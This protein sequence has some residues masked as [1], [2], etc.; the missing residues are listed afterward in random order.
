MCGFRPVEQ[1]AADIARVPALRDAIGQI[2][3]DRFRSAMEEVAAAVEDGRA[4]PAEARRMK[5][6]ALRLAFAALIEADA[7]HVAERVREVVRMVEAG[8][9]VA[10]TDRLV[11]NLDSYF[12]GDVGCFAPYFLNYLE[13][14][15]G[16]AFVMPANE[17]HAYLSGEC[18]EVMACSDN[19]VRVG[20]TPKAKDTKTLLDML[21][22][23]DMMPQVLNGVQ[24][25]SF[26]KLYQPPRD[27]QEFQ[28]DL[29]RLP[30]G[31]MVELAAS[32]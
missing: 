14:S 10:A 12:T 30:K 8:K 18:V 29:V 7:D 27:I 11:A 3:A 19:V 1:T 24:T 21:T 5:S 4:D 20:L 15:A 25:N 13:I 17:P 32:P 9:D 6:D 23:N 2:Q 31:E 28:L 22:Y 26:T 16:E